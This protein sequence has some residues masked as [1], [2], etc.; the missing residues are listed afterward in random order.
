M[1]LRELREANKLSQLDA[2]D[3]GGIEQTTVSQLEL[4]KVRDPRHS[5]LKALAL[6]YGCSVQDVATALEHTLREAE[7]A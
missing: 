3:R 1:N 2:A 4:G 5:T 6:A 7:A